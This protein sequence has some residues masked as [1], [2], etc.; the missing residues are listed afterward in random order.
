[1]ETQQAKNAYEIRR[2]TCTVIRKRKGKHAAEEIRER[3]AD[4]TRQKLC[5]LVLDPQYVYSVHY[6]RDVT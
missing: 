6:I 5:L 3:G 2:T 4:A 1:V